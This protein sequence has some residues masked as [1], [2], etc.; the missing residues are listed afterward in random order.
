MFRKCWTVTVGGMTYQVMLGRDGYRVE[1]F[2][3][4]QYP[5]F[6]GWVHCDVSGRTAA[7]IVRRG[8]PA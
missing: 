7:E 8:R 5:A 1:K 6:S 3:R 4:G 2:I